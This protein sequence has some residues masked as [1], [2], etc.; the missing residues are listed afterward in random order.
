MISCWH[1]EQHQ[2]CNWPSYFGIFLPRCQWF[3]SKYYQL[4]CIIS[5]YHVGG[6]SIYYL[7]VNGPGQ[8]NYH[9]IVKPI[10]ETR[11]ES[12]NDGSTCFRTGGIN[13][14]AGN[15]WSWDCSN[16]AILTQK[17]ASLKPPSHCDMLWKF[18]AAMNGMADFLLHCLEIAGYRF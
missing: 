15:I 11:K 8:Y 3:S 12:Y 6:D 17:A 7:T 18:I 4:K 14:Q 1:R 9:I 13:I 16:E 2:P 5:V 10:S